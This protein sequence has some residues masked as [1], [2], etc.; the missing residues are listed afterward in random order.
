MK[1]QLLVVLLLVVSLLA[2]CGGAD[3][4]EPTATAMPA[5]TNT[6][7][8]ASTPA[9]AD[10]PT[11]EPIPTKESQLESPLDTRNAQISPLLADSPLATPILPT[12]IPV[13][14]FKIDTPVYAGMDSISG[15]GPANLPLVL[16]NITDGG[17]PLGEAET[18]E[19]G[20]FEMDLDADLL[21][22]RRIGLTIGDLSDSELTY[23]HFLDRGFYGDTALSVPRIGFFYTTLM[24]VEEPE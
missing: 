8:P 18:D 11:D 19:D 1:R 4:P 15:S 6:S 14:Q 12:P 7:A 23:E 5:P 2:G 16:I 10:T 21:A 3:E 17:E 9:P 22:G 20:N 13:V 24:V